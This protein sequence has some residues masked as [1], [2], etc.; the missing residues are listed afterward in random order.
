MANSAKDVANSIEQAVQNEISAINK[1]VEQLANF[2]HS[3]LH[4]L[5]DNELR[6]TKD[7]YKNAISFHALENNKYEIRLDLTQAGFVEEGLSAH[8]MIQDLLTVRS[9]AKGQVKEVKHGKN[10]GKKY[11][12]IP[13]KQGTPARHTG[14]TPNSAAVLNSLNKILK[15]H[16]YNMKSTDVDIKDGKVTPK[17]FSHTLP[18][19]TRLMP[20]RKDGSVVGKTPTLRRVMVQQKMGDDNRYHKT[21]TTFRIAGEWQQGTGLWD[22]PGIQAKKL[23]DKVFDIVSKEADDIFVKLGYK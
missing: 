10:K 21:A 7:L 8:N 18:N 5:A 4:E 22:H 13:M 19:K 2:A 12:I 15:Q 11:R 9:G 6:S 16:N 23:M 14:S 3:K 1:A 20:Q 17:T